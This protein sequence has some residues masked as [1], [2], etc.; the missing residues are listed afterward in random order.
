MCK[1]INQKYGFISKLYSASFIILNHVQQPQMLKPS[2]ALN[3]GTSYEPKSIFAEASSPF[4]QTACIHQAAAHA[5]QIFFFGLVPQ[6][7]F[8]TTDPWFHIVASL[9]ITAAAGKKRRRSVVST[10]C[11]SKPAP[12]ASW[13]LLL[14]IWSCLFRCIFLS[15]QDFKFLRQCLHFRASVNVLQVQ[16]VGSKS[17]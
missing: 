12:Y 13:P 10:R 3:K 11:S 8:V 16:P 4:L 7:V 15:R 1:P 9:H 6:L 14:S 5:Q 2:E 17:N